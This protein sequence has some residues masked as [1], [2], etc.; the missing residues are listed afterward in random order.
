ML[1]NPQHFWKRVEKTDDCWWF[2]GYRDSRGY[3]YLYLTGASSNS[4]HRISYEEA[5]GPIPHGLHIDHLCRHPSCVNPAHL[6]AVSLK[7][8]VLRG[9]GIT[10]RNARKTH[11]P[12]GHEYSPE[13]TYRD[14]TGKRSC[15]ACGRVA[16]LAYYHRGRRTA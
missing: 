5:K 1:K 4:A 14:K 2:T 7:E 8:N 13:N 15:K 3:G 16:A 11:C 9:I 10:A 6:E 12:K